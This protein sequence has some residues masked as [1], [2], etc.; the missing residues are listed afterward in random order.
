[1]AK[2][3]KPGGTV[4]A[5]EVDARLALGEF[6]ATASIYGLANGIGLNQWE[7]PFLNE[8]DARQV[9]A[10]AVGATVLNE[11]MTL[12]LRVIFETE[13]KIVLFGDSF[14]VTATGAKSLLSGRIRD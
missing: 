10:A 3:L 9:G 8:D 4:A 7:A 5:I 12:A 6:Y 1:M 14:Q 2:Q 11:N 13:G